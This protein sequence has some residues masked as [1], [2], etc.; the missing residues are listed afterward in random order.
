MNRTITLL[1]LFA[2]FA[3]GCQQDGG[4]N[5]SGTGP[6]YGKVG[7]PDPAKME[8]AA[9]A[10]SPIVNKPAPTYTL[11]NQNDQPVNL[12]GLRG[13]WVVLYFYPKDDTPG[14]ACQANEFTQLLTEFRKHNAAIYGVSADSPES[15]R[16]FI[17]KYSLKIDLLSDPDHKVMEAYGAWVQAHLG[18]EG[19]GRVIRSTVVIDPQGVIRHHWPEV[20]PEG[21]A[22]RVREKL[23]QLQAG[24]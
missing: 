24:R 9:S 15:H 2:L 6:T 21:H 8:A 13:Q 5:A 1:A 17:E 11:S 3:I 4:G 23:I 20:I 12:A 18:S 22:E 7:K 19:Y 10:S 16:Q 14:C